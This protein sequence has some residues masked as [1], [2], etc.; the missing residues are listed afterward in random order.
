MRCWGHPGFWLP[1]TLPPLPPWVPELGVTVLTKAIRGDRK[2]GRRPYIQYERVRYTNPIL[3]SAYD[4][5]GRQIRIHV[6]VEDLRTVKA[7]LPSGEEIG[8]LTAATG[9]NRIQHDRGLRQNVNRAIHDKS[10]AVAP[11]EDAIQSYLVLKAQ[12]ALEQRDAKKSRRHTV[13]PAGTAL[14]RAV[15]VSAQPVPAIP[16]RALP[17]SDSPVPLSLRNASL[18]SFVPQVRHRGVVK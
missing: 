15:R 3:A 17:A 5:I 16:S 7:F 13:S 12:Q 10:L 18:P 11:G 1:R 6:N 14:A 4:L 8:V 9:W 2:Q